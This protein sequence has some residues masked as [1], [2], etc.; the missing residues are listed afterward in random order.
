M[1]P[2]VMPV[3]V[4]H[5][6]YPWI[7]VGLRSFRRFF[8]DSPILIIDNNLDFGLPGYDSKVE[9]EREWLKDWCFQ[10]SHPY[11]EKTELLGKTHGAGLDRA[12]KWCKDHEVRWMLH[13]EPDC[14]IDGVEWANR[15]L[16]A[17]RKDIWM[18]GSYQI[19]GPIHLTPSIWD[20]NHIESGFDV[21]PRG[22]DDDHPSFH[23]LVNM[24]W[25]MTQIGDDER[26]FWEVLWDTAQKPWFDAA[27]HGKALLVEGSSDFRHFWRGSTSNTDPSKIDDSRVQQYLG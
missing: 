24:K 25:L 6:S 16:E 15:L 7:K 14:L 8:P 3:I 23:K 1:I 5:N 11:L 27:I 21:Q 22:S 20:V 26:G 4:S 2:S 9:V 18:A 17:T 12:V 10:D 19:F 13:F